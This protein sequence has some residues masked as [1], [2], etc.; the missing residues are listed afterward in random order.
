MYQIYRIVRERI[1][2]IRCEILQANAI[3]FYLNDLD[4]EFD[5]TVKS[6][7]GCNIKQTNTCLTVQIV[8]A[9]SP[10][11]PASEA[12]KLRLYLTNIQRAC[13]PASTP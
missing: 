2:E 13:V 9:T 10:L 6:S 5:N 3:I 7:L 8:K 12:F 11:N 1:I 4:V